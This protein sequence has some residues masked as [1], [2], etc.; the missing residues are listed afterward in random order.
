L[1]YDFV[2][3]FV[4]TVRKLDHPPTPG[5]DE[6]P[7]KIRRSQTHEF[8]VSGRAHVKDLR[9]E[10]F[11]IGEFTNPS[12]KKRIVEGS[13][14][15]GDLWQLT[16]A[17]DEIGEWSYLLRGEGVEIWRRGQLQCES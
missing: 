16:F 8:Q 3:A 14:A 13:Y 9:R 5:T 6:P 1:G 10:A 7:I 15:G 11:L 12:G 4:D 17:P 2:R